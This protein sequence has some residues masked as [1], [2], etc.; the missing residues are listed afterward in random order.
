MLGQCRQIAY[1][2]G[3]DA[4]FHLADENIQQHGHNALQLDDKSQLVVVYDLQLFSYEKVLA[5]MS[6]KP[7]KQITLGTFNANN[8]I[9]IT[10]KETLR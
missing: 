2:K 1:K 8:G 5:I 4:T 9:I 10:H 3:L 7:D 6:T